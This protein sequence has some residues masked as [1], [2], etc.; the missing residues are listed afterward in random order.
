MPTLQDWESKLYNIYLI[1]DYSSI[2]PFD[3]FVRY[4]KNSG[5]FDNMI[6]YSFEDTK[7]NGE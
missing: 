5:R 1:E 2:M 7:N 3:D 4:A 6:G